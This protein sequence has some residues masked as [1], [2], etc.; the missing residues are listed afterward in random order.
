MDFRETFST[1][2]TLEIHTNFEDIAEQIVEFTT[3]LSFLQ[4]NI[5]S[6]DAIYNLLCV[7]YFQN[8]DQIVIL[9]KINAIIDEMKK[10]FQQ[11]VEPRVAFVDI[12]VKNIPLKMLL[13]EFLFNIKPTISITELILNLRIYFQRYVLSNIDIRGMKSTL[14]QQHILP[15]W[16]TLKNK[17][18]QELLMFFEK[19][20]HSPHMFISFALHYEKIGLNQYF[21]HVYF[22]GSSNV[23]KIIRK[24]FNPVPFLLSFI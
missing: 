10:I 14:Q 13:S 6:N 3:I 4:L 7:F 19:L 23:A 11:I 22:T 16:F 12:A 18:S 1:G 8:V 15:E 17:K 9:T 5:R 2:D 20:R 24:F 21:T